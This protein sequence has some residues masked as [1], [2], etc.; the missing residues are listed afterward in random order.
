MNADPVRITLLVDNQPGPDL[1]AEHGLA[2]WIETDRR[3][4]LFDT[5]QGTALAAN[6]R[7]LGVDLRKT[8]ILVLSHGHYDHTGG[9]SK[10]LKLAPQAQIYGHAKVLQPRYRIREGKPKAIHMP[11]ESRTAIDQ[12]PQGQIHWV[13]GPRELS[14]KI[15][16]T[17]P[18]PRKT[19]YEDPGGPFYLDP[20]GLRA[21]PIE[22]DL[23]LWIWTGEGLVICVG[24]CHAGLINT[25]QHVR[26]LSRQAPI[27]AVIGGFHLIAASADRLDQTMAALQ[28][29]SLSLVVPC[30]CTGERSVE[31]MKRTLGDR[32]VAGRSG[33]TWLF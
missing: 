1:L 17:G 22:D 26:H 20:Q 10:V 31:R 5:G 4:I 24:C 32:T 25:L 13:T 33:M 21:D 11:Q 8:D 2:V 9:I 27:R 3:R 6:A 15:G 30:H 19:S 29:L 7:A 12:L 14:E 23:A 18:I 16:I 28:S